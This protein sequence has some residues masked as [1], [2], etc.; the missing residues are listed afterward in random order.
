[1]SGLA[2]SGATDRFVTFTR[3]DRADGSL[4]FHEG[5]IL[6]AERHQGE[7]RRWSRL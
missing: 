2:N 3:V 4:E 7:W 6:E 1:M 5:A